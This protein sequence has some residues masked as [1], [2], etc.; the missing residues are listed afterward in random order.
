[1]EEFTRSNSSGETGSTL[2]EV[3]VAM[4]IL[5]TGMLSMAKLMTTATVTNTGARTETLASVFAEQK[6]E[7]L[8]SLAYGFDMAGLPVTD[9]DTD[10]SVSPEAPGGTGLQPSGNSLQQN[11]PGFVDHVD[12]HGQIVGNGAKAPATAVY[13][14]RWSIEPLPT[15]PNNTIIIQVLVTPNRARGDADLGNVARLAGEARV[16]TVKTRKAQ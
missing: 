4:V 7:Q 16:M 13:T 12:A 9:I 11:T 6:I 10:T 2:V 14:R 5:M 3:L 15:N 1:L 8:R